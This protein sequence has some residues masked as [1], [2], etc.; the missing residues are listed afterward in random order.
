MVFTKS[1]WLKP[2]PVGAVYAVYAGTDTVS[3]KLTCC[4][5]CVHLYICITTSQPQPEI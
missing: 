4:A 3:I 5:T 1:L 2:V